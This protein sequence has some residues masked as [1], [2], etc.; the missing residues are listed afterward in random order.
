MYVC[1]Q[2]H[3]AFLNS[4][5]VELKYLA[6]I[7]GQPLVR[8]SDSPD[9]MLIIAQGKV[10]VEMQH[11]AATYP[12]LVLG[13]GDFVAD[14]ALLGI[15]TGAAPPTYR[16]FCPISLLISVTISVLSVT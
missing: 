13:A 3:E 5:F 15:R 12:N 10:E 14:M 7:P 2:V 8:F 11:E 16:I 1:I 6:F 9:R 4:L